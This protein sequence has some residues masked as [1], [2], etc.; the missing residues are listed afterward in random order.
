MARPKRKQ[1][2]VDAVFE[3]RALPTPEQLASGEF[4]DDFITQVDSNTK[5]KAFRRTSLVERWMAEDPKTF[6]EPARRVIGD[7]LM[8]WA[9]LGE[10]RLVAL[11]GE[12]M[13]A[14]TNGDGHA[15]HD[16][17]RRLTAMREALG[18]HMRH[19]WSVWENVLRF[20]LSA[21]VAGTHFA[22]NPAQRIQSAKVIVGM[23]ANM[24]A[25]RMG[26]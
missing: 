12:R 16:A 1:R 13:P 24:L 6:N 26:Y 9:R 11:Y 15:A 5:A 8:L 18:P 10:P 17:Q 2:K 3:P 19:Y 14:S 23:V 22:N 4:V 20:G 25:G 21:G 7:C